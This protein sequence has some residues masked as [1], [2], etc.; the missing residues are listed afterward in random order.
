M[1]SKSVYTRPYIVNVKGFHCRRN[2][3][4]LRKVQEE[5][6]SEDDFEDDTLQDN[7]HGSVM[8][9]DEPG[10]GNIPVEQSSIRM[11]RSGRTIKPP[12]RLN[13]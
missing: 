9:D 4:H 5:D 12:D 11:S 6:K 8:C 13:L 7:G 3:R 2:R 10:E 1:I